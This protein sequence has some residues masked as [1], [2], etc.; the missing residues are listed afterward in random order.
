MTKGT[1]NHYSCALL[2]LHARAGL[3]RMRATALLI[4][5]TARARSDLCCLHV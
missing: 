2:F 3:R 4:Q 1:T 5:M